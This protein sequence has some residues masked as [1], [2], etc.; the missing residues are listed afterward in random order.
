[1]NCWL[2]GQ[3]IEE[4]YAEVHT[5]PRVPPTNLHPGECVD[6][7]LGAVFHGSVPTPRVVYPC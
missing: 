1:M 2:C 4:L 7:F 6:Q 3:P 5:D